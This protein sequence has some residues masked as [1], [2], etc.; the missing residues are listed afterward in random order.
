MPT[1]LITG[2][3]RGIGFEFAR[4]YAA[5]GWRI[6]AGARNPDE[7]AALKS[8]DSSN[9]TIHR[10]DVENHNEIK[11]LAATLSGEAIDVLINNA[12]LWIG[13]DEHFGRFSNEQWMEQFR[14]HVFGTMAMCEAFEDHV[15]TSERRLIVNISSGNGCFSWPR[16]EGDYPYDTSKAALNL[17]TK[18][19]SVD[20]RDRGIT[21]MCFTPG[22]VATDM[23]GPN[24][25][26]QPDESIS[27]MRRV[28]AQLDV[29]Q[30]GSFVRYNGDAMPW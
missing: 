6:H 14:V 7:A 16:E 22:N 2:A 13:E 11:A 17:I 20:L 30:T 21:V 9:V 29:S 27:G 10:L 28:I 12:G 18:G 26:L 19:L 24:A 23:S 5:E 15:A 25:E 3:N 4:Q 8:L 1:V